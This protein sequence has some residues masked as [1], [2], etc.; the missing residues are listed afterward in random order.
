MPVV[1]AHYRR[2]T[3]FRNIYQCG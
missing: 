1:A 3:R 2:G